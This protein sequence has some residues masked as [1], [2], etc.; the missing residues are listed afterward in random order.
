M[1]GLSLWREVPMD[2]IAR[3]TQEVGRRLRAARTGAGL[4]LA[5]VAA[6][7]NVSEG[8]LSKLE[9]GRAA[10]S[11][12]NLVQLADALGLGLHELFANDGAPAKTRVA[13]HRAGT[14]APNEVAAT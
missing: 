8:F 10:A 12:A 6:R 4:T 3:A 9:R 2:R 11:I 5:N 13:V 1:T 14:E 7:A